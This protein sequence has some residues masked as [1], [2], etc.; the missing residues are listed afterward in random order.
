MTYGPLIFFHQYIH[1][2]IHKPR[3]NFVLRSDGGS[4]TWLES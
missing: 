1:G 2:F 3:G 4:V